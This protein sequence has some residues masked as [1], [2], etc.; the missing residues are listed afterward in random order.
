MAQTMTT[1][2]MSDGQVERAVELFEAQL[3]KQASRFSREA[4]QMAFSDSTLS[5]EWVRV[6]S[7]R[8]KKIECMIVRHV[9]NVD[10]TRSPHEVLDAFTCLKHICRDCVDAM[11]RGTGSG[12]DV[13]FFKLKFKRGIY[14]YVED[15]YL[16]RE[17]ALRGLIPADPYSLAQVNLDDPDFADNHPNTTQWRDIDGGVVYLLFDSNNVDSRLG[18]HSTAH[19]LNKDFWYA[20][21]RKQ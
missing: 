11:P 1:S 16:A 5:V 6:L 3:R 7:S 19:N 15:A 14:H 9:E 13:Y 12:A 21:L 18:L 2:K 4:V 20:G 10:R 17:Y 8:V